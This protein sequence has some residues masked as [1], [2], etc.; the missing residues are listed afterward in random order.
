MS[1]STMANPVLRSVF[2]AAFRISLL[3]VPLI[4]SSYFP[5]FRARR[6]ISIGGTI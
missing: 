2:V 6:L 5:D 1:E 3:T 4:H